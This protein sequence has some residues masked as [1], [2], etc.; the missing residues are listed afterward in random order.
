M[1]EISKLRKS[2][3]SSVKKF[4]G[5]QRFTFFSASSLADDRWICPICLDIFQDAV[6]TPCCHNLFCEGCIRNTRSCPLCNQRIVGALRPNIPIRRLVLELS[7][8]CPNQP[9]GQKVKRCDLERHLET[10]EY[11]LVECPNNQVCGEI[12]RKDLEKHT[13]YE[14]HYR[15]VSCLLQCGA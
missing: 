6:E 2:T 4:D 1:S 7:V 9:C 3:N 10:C 15:Q 13:T 14:C 12:I 5:P 11:S 8:A